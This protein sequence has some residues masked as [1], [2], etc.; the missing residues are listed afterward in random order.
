MKS[1]VLFLAKKLVTEWVIKF[2][3]QKKNFIIGINILII[4]IHLILHY[5]FYNFETM[6]THFDFD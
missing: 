1:D 3:K 6:R 4:F 5:Y 2:S